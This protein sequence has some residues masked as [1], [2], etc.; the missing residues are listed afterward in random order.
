VSLNDPELDR[1][2]QSFLF[3][4]GN[5]DVFE[6]LKD[7]HPFLQPAPSLRRSENDFRPVGHAERDAVFLLAVCPVTVHHI[8][9][10]PKDI[11]QQAFAVLEH[12]LLEFPAAHAVPLH[13]APKMNWDH[14]G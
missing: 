1:A 14:S 5:L 4:L 8:L 2:D 13:F 7:G 11:R 6:R 3:R 12:I 10:P 9:K